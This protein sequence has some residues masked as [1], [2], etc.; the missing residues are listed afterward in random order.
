MNSKLTFAFTILLAVTLFA[1]CGEGKDPYEI[2][3][4]SQAIPT[5]A[6]PMDVSNVGG[7]AIS[8]A[9]DRLDITVAGTTATVPLVSPVNGIVT[10]IDGVGPYTL[11]IFHNSRFSIQI[12]NLGTLPGVRVGDAVIEGQILA[13][14]YT[15]S[16][17]IYFSVFQ[18]GAAVCPL[19]AF[20]A[21]ARDRIR[22][23]TPVPCP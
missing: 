21:T 16:P 14:V 20:N 7:A 17:L 9:K 12:G 2:F 1:G 4:N 8:P 3:G 10:A 6:L 22:A 23:F 15:I 19:V 11:T 5:I 18:N 13:A